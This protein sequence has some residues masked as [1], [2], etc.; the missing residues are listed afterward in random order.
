[1]QASYLPSKVLHIDA[2][3]RLLQKFSEVYPGEMQESPDDEKKKKKLL[4]ETPKEQALADEFTP[5][6]E[7]G[8]E[9]V[10][11]A[12]EEKE[13]K[14]KGPIKKEEV[15]T[16]APDTPEDVTGTIPTEKYA[17]IYED[18]EARAA[19]EKIK[20]QIDEYVVEEE[21]AEKDRSQ[22]ESRTA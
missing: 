11:V 17:K 4:P 7:E 8:G 9:E 3:R 18:T 2:E 15:V 10:V 14:K 1:M 20:D 22:R 12:K 19:L 13:V 6:G 21:S 16:E 5:E